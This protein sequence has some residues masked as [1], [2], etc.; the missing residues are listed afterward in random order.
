MYKISYVKAVVKIRVFGMEN[1]RRRHWR[2][3]KSRLIYKRQ[4]NL[5]K[6]IYEQSV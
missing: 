6:I 5:F 4:L 2:R 3:R 1:K